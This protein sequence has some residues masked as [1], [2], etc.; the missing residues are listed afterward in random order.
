MLGIDE[1]ELAAV[2]SGGEEVGELSLLFFLLLVPIIV[3]VSLLLLLS[4]ERV[5]LLQHLHIAPQHHNCRG[6][7][8]RRE[9]HEGVVDEEDE[10]EGLRIAGRD[11]GR[12]GQGLDDLRGV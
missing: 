12:G 5:G 6:V 3:L 9:E 7:S 4:H 1:L 10:A 2:S 8:V 11:G